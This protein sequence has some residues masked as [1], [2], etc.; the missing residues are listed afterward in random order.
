MNKPLT[1]CKWLRLV[2]L[3]ITLGILIL[4]AIIYINEPKVRSMTLQE[5][6]WV[7]SPDMR[8]YY[9]PG[10]PQSRAVIQQL[11]DKLDIKSF[12][13]IPFICARTGMKEG[14]AP[15][16][17]LIWEIDPNNI[18]NQKLQLME[19]SSLRTEPVPEDSV[20]SPKKSLIITQA[21]EEDGFTSTL[22]FKASNKSFVLQPSPIDWRGFYTISP[23]ERWV[24][25][26][27]KIGSGDNNAWLYEV[28]DGAISPEYDLGEIAWEFYEKVS[29]F[30][31]APLYHTGFR[32]VE[33]DSQGNLVL[34]MHGTS[35]EQ[36]ET[37]HVR[38]F[39]V[40]YNLSTKQ[41]TKGQ[42]AAKSNPVPRSK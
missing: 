17:P 10:S 9:P 23:D 20:I 21:Y 22:T 40:K 37:H 18:P 36:I 31:N 34:T 25:R 7:C 11:S 39:V 35:D 13:S 1:K 28:K 30:K 32:F 6:L 15:N 5:A 2:L 14:S 24:L 38:G 26:I 42:S 27:Q 3:S 19:A 12:R 33:W 8:N 4:L 29:A 41:F 16:E